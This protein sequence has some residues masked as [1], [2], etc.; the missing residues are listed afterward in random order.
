MPITIYRT[1]NI[2]WNILTFLQSTGLK[3]KNG[4]EIWKGDIVRWEGHMDYV[5][6]WFPEWGMWYGEPISKIPAS[7][8]YSNLF[9]KRVKVI[10]NVHEH[11]EL[12]KEGV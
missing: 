11:K 5:V 4:V 12:L 3:D 8:D 9:W 2:D 6:T 10:G 7:W 1:D